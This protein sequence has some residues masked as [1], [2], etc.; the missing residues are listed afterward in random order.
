MITRLEAYNYRCF[1]DLSVDLDRYQVLAGA[2]GSGKTTML[3]IP[4][5]IGD[6]LRSRRG[7]A[8]AFLRR[9]DGRQAR[10]T[11]LNE[12]LRCRGADDLRFI[13]EAQLP[14]N[15]AN[16]L[17]DISSASASTPPPT[18]ARYEIRLELFNDRLLVAEEYLFLFPEG[19]YAPAA[20]SGLL[21]SEAGGKSKATRAWRKVIDR[22]VVTST[23]LF[24][25]TV[26]SSRRRPHSEL[27]IVSDQLALDSIPADPE[28]FPATH[29]LRGLLDAGAVFYEPDWPQLRMPSAPGDPETVITSGRNTPWLARTLH[30][31]DPE[32]FADWIDH[33]RTALPQITD[34]GV[35][36]REEDRHAYFVVEYLGGH[37]VTSSGLSEGTLRILALTLLNYLPLSALPTV[38]VTEEPEN[39][40]HPQAIEAVM[41]SLGS[42]YTAQVL[43]S[44]HSPIVLA[45]TELS[46]ILT[47]RLDDDGA[48]TIIP[49]TDHPRLR[50]WQGGID[51]GQLFA[52]GVFA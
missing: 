42:I 37:S 18:H 49:G 3:D 34:I 51:L 35:R 8:D 44:T 27:S 50:H 17:A 38:L 36:V 52:S 21:G 45:Q 7:L 32:R 41:Q 16:Q 33:V 2:N 39:G 26:Q 14:S 15:V 48:A 13:V 5:L 24:R 20:R 23:T 11:G 46:D 31:A 43:V 47:A 6:M 25:E 22:P 30:T 10:A 4:I 28:L 9:D 40:I 12:L 1:I 19:D 29:W